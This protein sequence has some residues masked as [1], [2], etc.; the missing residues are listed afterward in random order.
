MSGKSSFVAALPGLQEVAPATSPFHS[1][2]LAA[3]FVDL[4]RRRE[5]LNGCH[6]LLEMFE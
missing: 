6:T 1:P 2:E 3:S 5:G 4:K